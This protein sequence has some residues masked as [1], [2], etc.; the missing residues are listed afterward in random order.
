ML[1]FK[2]AV[3]IS[4]LILYINYSQKKYDERRKMGTKLFPVVLPWSCKFLRLA[5]KEK[6]RDNPIQAGGRDRF[7]L[8]LL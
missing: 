1:I 7:L 2:A 3:C 4:T 5:D 8:G 6:K